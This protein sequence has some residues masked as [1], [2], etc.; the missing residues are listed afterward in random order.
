MPKHFEFQILPLFATIPS[1]QT[2]K[3][4][5]LNTAPRISKY[6]LLAIAVA[7]SLT[8]YANSLGGGF[9][10]DD[11]HFIVENEAIKDLS[12]IP[13]LFIADVSFSAGKGKSNYYRPFWFLVLMADYHI[14]GL[15]PWGF[16]LTHILLHGLV[17]A[18]VFLFASLITSGVT[19]GVI[20]G[21]RGGARGGA[22]E[23]GW[24]GPYR[25]EPFWAV[26]FWA[27]LLFATHPIHSMVV[28]GN[29][30][31]EMGM[32]LFVILA[33]YFYVRGR[34]MTGALCFFLAAL[35][36]ETA[37]VLPAAI[38]AWDA[39]FNKGFLLPVTREKLAAALKRYLPYLSAA[40]LY[41][42]L[43]TYAL[44]GFASVNHHKDLTFY[45]YLINVP[46]LFAK[47]MWNLLVP[48]G[49]N[50]A[51]TFHPVHS[52]LDWRSLLGLVVLGA[53]FAALAYLYRSRGTVFFLM[54]FMVIPLL[55]VLYIP[56]MGVHVFAENY[57]YLPGVA[58]SVLSVLF[59]FALFGKLRSGPFA[60]AAGPFAPPRLAIAFVIS[61]TLIYT[62]GTVKRIP[63]WRSEF[64]L[65]S[66]TVRKSPGSFTVQNNM[67]RALAARGEF[68]AALKYF[69][70]AVALR[71]GF[72]EAMVNLANTYV[73]LGRQAEAVALYMV[74]IRAFP[75]A[76]EA[77]YNLGVVFERAGRL[78]EALSRYESAL[79]ISPS[80]MPARKG[81]M[82][83]NRVMGSG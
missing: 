76:F 9:V 57:L 26:P 27:A 23:G 74:I 4:S 63:V 47:Y 56:V 2:G 44:G 55:P 80:F 42:G 49:L 5:E 6:A 79:R 28:N 16:H 8:V 75:G 29:G 66:D 72:M 41:M 14:F 20:G 22:R 53:Y 21:V 24:G 82:R 77:Y 46:P 19:S 70:R 17:T 35:F 38:L 36:K 73:M 34:H 10:Y 81:V 62:V 69:Q 65:W 31:P 61:L 12:N 18:A 59:A 83:L 15:V 67:G 7:V 30:S 40:A 48:V 32:V 71:P 78:A 60:R 51:H 52:L 33:L 43:R 25:S 54:I 3:N 11:R 64:T 68:E 45:E 39:S 50:A 37:M 1:M 58:F 13:G